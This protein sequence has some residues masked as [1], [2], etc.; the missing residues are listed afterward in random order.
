MDSREDRIFKIRTGWMIGLIW[1]M[2]FLCIWRLAVVQV[3]EQNKYE[4][5]AEIQQ[6]KTIKA[7]P[8]RGKIVDRNKRDFATTNL[9]YDMYISPR[10][11][12]NA[13][14]GRLW[15]TTQLREAGYSEAQ[16]KAIRK[17][18]TEIPKELPEEVL[19]PLAEDIASF[20]NRNVDE[21]YKIVSGQDRQTT[22]TRT[23]VNNT[24]KSWL[25]AYAGILGLHHFF[26]DGMFSQVT[27]E[28]VQVQEPLDIVVK[29]QVTQEM[30][31]RFMEMFNKNRKGDPK[32][33]IRP[34][35]TYTTSS[36]TVISENAVYFNGSNN[37]NYPQGELAGTVVGLTTGNEWGDNLG[38]FGIE[39]A[40]DD[41]LR[42]TSTGISVRVT[43]GQKNLD[44]LTTDITKIG[45]GHTVI[46]TIDE[47]MQRE[48]E[49]ALQFHV[50]RLSADGGQAVVM[51]VK[52][53]EILAMASSPS[54]DPERRLGSGK[55][56]SVNDAVEPGSVMKIFVY[57]AVMDAGK[58][59][60]NT[61]IDCGGLT[62]T[63][64]NG[65]KITDTHA[66]GTVPA[67]RAF[68]ESSNIGSVKTFNQ[69]G[70]SPPYTAAYN[71]LAKFG[72]GELTG[73][74][75]PFE[76]PGKLR[77]PKFW[78]GLSM[79]SLAQGYEI[80]VTPV[81]VVSAIAAIGNGGMYMQ[82]HIVKGIEDYDG[83]VVRTIEPKVVRRVC[84]EATSK[85]MLSM[86][87]QVVIDGTAMTAR[88][89]N[90]RVGGKTGTTMKSGGKAGYG[91]NKYVGSF[92]GLAPITDPKLAIYVWVDNPTTENRQYFGGLS[93]API[94]RDI[95]EAGMNLYN[96][97]KQEVPL[98]EDKGKL[99][100]LNST[101][102][103]IARAVRN[104][105]VAPTA[106]AAAAGDTSSSA[107]MNTLS[108]LVDTE[109]LPDIAPN[110]MPDLRGKSLREAADV[111]KGINLPFEIDG[112]G[113][114]VKQSPEPFMPFEEGDVVK[115]KLGTLTEAEMAMFR[116]ELPDL[117]KGKQSDAADIAG[118]P[119]P[120]E[121][122]R[123]GQLL[124]KVGHETIALPTTS[125][126]SPMSRQ[127][128]MEDESGDLPTSQSRENAERD[129]R[130]V[131]MLKPISDYSSAWRNYDMKNA[132]DEERKGRPTQIELPTST[133]TGTPTPD[134]RNPSQTKPAAATPVMPGTAKPPV[135]SAYD[136][137]PKNT[138]NLL[139]DRVPATGNKTPSGR[140]SPSSTNS[141]GEK[142]SFYDYQN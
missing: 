19:R 51:D 65:R 116:D 82:P 24:Q 131:P 39:K 42:G 79:G 43:A 100:K 112:T 98:P 134:D 9:T 88:L 2:I 135:K 12:T 122:Q 105:L 137:Q 49:R 81:Q 125:T 64:S 139:R 69:L 68:A 142:K 33:G 127:I 129:S 15:T 119:S 62:W 102:D 38:A 22:R 14:A 59:T 89:D 20:T 136:L 37:R 45:Y 16:V 46:M 23:I 55:N 83:R 13:Q 138:G 8:I 4:V 30:R 117:N 133:G 66:I 36:M 84:S 92:C 40:Y 103:S 121:S 85:K 95:A 114:V 97:P 90:W 31:D 6:K 113:V 106:Q 11:C 91:N 126:V 25:Q 70:A 56:R 63:M 140:T 26:P 87:E 124:I 47:R 34:R 80:L 67:I 35:Y 41:D 58:V 132:S 1:L 50:G 7:P 128:R 94:F 71:A 115:L 72:F 5:K 52:T 118:T 86:L 18:R 44:A 73:I 108:K 141:S 29:R 77:K 61:I 53:G 104:L 57:T 99:Y 107:L 101:R 32:N 123:V 130:G 27:R 28:K 75:L 10:D 21:I 54:F 93:A 3:V 109:E 76:I 120:E 74:D 17:N 78:S 111:L 96:I 48:T 60:P 110:S